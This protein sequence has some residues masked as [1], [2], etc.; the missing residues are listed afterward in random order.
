MCTITYLPT[1]KDSFILTSN[2]DESKVRPTFPPAI[3]KA[4][5]VKLLFPKDAVAGGTWICISSK[6]RVACLMNGAFEK[7]AWNPPYR[8]SRGLVVL[9]LFQY[10]SVDDFMNGYNFEG[11]EPFTLIIYDRLSMTEFRWDG[12]DKYSK[13]IDTLQPH[14][15]SSASL[16]PRAVRERRENWFRKW[17]EGRKKFLQ[18]EILEFHRFGG[19]GDKENDFV[20]NRYDIVQTVSITSIVKTPQ[21]AAM[22]YHD[23]ID[24]RISEITIEFEQ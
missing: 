23:L 5:N 13:A 19:E 24:S 2:R 21:Q 12:K 9:D 10:E 14:I 15:W 20:M 16:Y 11:I 3:E 22:R 1:H 4:G 18:D 17:L 8:K 7:H 6:N